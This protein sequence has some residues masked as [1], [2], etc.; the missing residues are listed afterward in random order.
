MA[1]L[2]DT[3]VWIR[4]FQHPEPKLVT[5]LETGDLLIHE[6]IIGEIAVGRVPKPRSTIND[7]LHL[8]FAQTVPFKELLDLIW[9]YKLISKGLSWVDIQLIGGALASEVELVTYDRPLA[10]AWKGISETKG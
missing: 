6:A 9:R 10:A 5:A 4:H 2:F 7:L 3:S 1:W 8:P